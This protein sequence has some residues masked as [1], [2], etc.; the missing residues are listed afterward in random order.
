M[1]RKPG[2]RIRD[3]NIE[4]STN[5]HGPRAAEPFSPWQLLVEEQRK[6]HQLPLREVAILAQ[7]PAGT[8]FNWLRAKKGAPPRVSYTANINSRLARALKIGEDELA[9]AYNSSAFRPVD[10]Q[11]IEVENRS[12]ARRQ[13][14]SPSLKLDGLKHLLAT[15]KA[16]GR[17]SFTISELELSIQMLLGPEPVPVIRPPSE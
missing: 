11:S 5:R 10:P 12:R 17:E 13:E 14:G 4:P 7:V 3:Y 8:L 1:A 15:L 16:S 6:I 2:A 9:Q